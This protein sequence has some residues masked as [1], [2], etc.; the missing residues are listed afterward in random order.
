M[1]VTGRLLATWMF[2]NSLQLVAHLVLFESQMPSHTAYVFGQ[3]LYL[4][5]FNPVPGWPGMNHWFGYLEE[6]GHNA[7]FVGY[8]YESLYFLANM[9]FIVFLAGALALMWLLLFLK[10][11]CAR[12]CGQRCRLKERFWYDRLEHKW[13]N[14]VNRVTYEVFLELVICTMISLAVR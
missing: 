10:D 2:L 11:K 7:R 6:G 5:R 12:K 8:T 3:L 13:H 14:M 4:A 1:L 9:N